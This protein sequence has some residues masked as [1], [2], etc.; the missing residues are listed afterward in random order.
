[1]KYNFLYIVYYIISITIGQVHSVIHK[2]TQNIFKI[3]SYLPPLSSTKMF[4]S[5]ATG[6]LN[7]LVNLLKQEQTSEISFS[8]T[9]HIV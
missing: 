5:A 1:M 2:K 3:R 9:L 8:K 7:G 4:V 6:I